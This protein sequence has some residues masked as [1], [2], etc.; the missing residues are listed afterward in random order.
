M[1]S[2]T[3]NKAMSKL[4][5]VADKASGSREIASKDKPKSSSDKMQAKD[6]GSKKP[7]DK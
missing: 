5:P 4:Q 7:S 3:K 6:S 1:D 2:S